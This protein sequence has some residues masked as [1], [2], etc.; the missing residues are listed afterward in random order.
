MTTNRRAL[1]GELSWAEYQRIRKNIK[2]LRSS[3]V[4]NWR[5][6]TK[7]KLIEYKG[8]KC[9]RCGFF[10]PTPTCYDFHHKDP[11][12][13]EFRIGG[14]TKSW[15]KLKRE[16]DKCE[17]LCRN[18]H[19]EEHDKG[20]TQ[21]RLESMDKYK[22]KM[23]GR[24]Q[25][26]LLLDKI[27]PCGQPFKA[28][29]LDQIHCSLE[30]SSKA[31]RKVARPSKEELTEKLQTIPMLQLGKSYGVS[32]N[33]V[34]KWCKGYGIVLGDRRGYWTKIKAQTINKGPVV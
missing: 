34:K 33:A 15:D 29:H 30:C 1:M 18:C 11:K 16:V 14:S 10:K 5:R 4:V 26:S 31:R 13:K 2:A 17:L 32:D 19:A 12:E 20:Y 28:G 9:E 24:A 6:R 23:T 3:Y 21:S 7:I 27:C 8:G 22:I 25:R